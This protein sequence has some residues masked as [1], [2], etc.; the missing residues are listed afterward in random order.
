MIVAYVGVITFLYIPKGVITFLVSTKGGHVF[1][2][3]V[4]LVATTPPPSR[5]NE[6]SPEL[7][8]ENYNFKVYH[9]FFTFVEPP[10]QK[11]NTLTRILQ[12][13]FHHCVLYQ[14][15]YFREKN[16]VPKEFFNEI[17]QKEV[18]HE[19]IYISEITLKK[20]SFRFKMAAKTCFNIAQY[21]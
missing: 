11:K 14:K 19:E 12:W 4:L 16:V 2:W 1:L 8:K 9:L 6:R 18:E 3:G 21:C 15:V 10:P 5:N 17:W 7:K 13:H 20:E